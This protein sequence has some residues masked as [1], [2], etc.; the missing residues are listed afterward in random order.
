MQDI[1]HFDVPAAINAGA[2][3]NIKLQE[4]GDINR[5][6]GLSSKTLLAFQADRFNASKKRNRILQAI[7]ILMG[8][9]K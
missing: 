1:Y 9:M 4:D 3:G 2:T 8:L 5:Q 7:E 6:A